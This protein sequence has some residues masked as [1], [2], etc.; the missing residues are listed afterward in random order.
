MTLLIHY[1][2]FTRMEEDQ[3]CSPGADLLA[4][5]S[6]A[7]QAGEWA[8]KNYEPGKTVIREVVLSG[9]DVVNRGP[10]VKLGG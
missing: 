10:E 9:Y 3:G 5:F 8:K 1:G 2:V 7:D 6:H 4:I